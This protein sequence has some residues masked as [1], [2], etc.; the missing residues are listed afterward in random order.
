MCDLFPSGFALCLRAARQGSDLPG[1]RR[2]D[3]GRAGK[4]MEN[5][6]VSRRRQERDRGAM[7]TASPDPSISGFTYQTILKTTS[8]DAVEQWGA[9]LREGAAT[10][11]LEGVGAHGGRGG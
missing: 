7:T 6:S 11:S 3:R 1:N 9:R 4:G 2:K 8:P 5:R 10:M